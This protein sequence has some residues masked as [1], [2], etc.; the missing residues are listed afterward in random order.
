MKDDSKGPKTLQRKDVPKLQ[1]SE[2]KLSM[3]VTGQLD[4]CGRV[5]AAKDGT[6]ADTFSLCHMSSSIHSIEDPN[7]F[8]V[9]LN[10]DIGNIRR[11]LQSL[12]VWLRL[13]R[14]RECEKTNRWA[15]AQ[16]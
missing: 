5:R 13:Q 2:L 8:A 15:A 3:R 11:I 7:A 12:T 10:T 4:V 16:P 9:I 14:I 1:F 6:K